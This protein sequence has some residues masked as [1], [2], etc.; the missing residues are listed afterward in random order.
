MVA[1]AGRELAIAHGAQF[2]AERLLGDR[3]LE[4]LEEPLDEV[5][6]PPAHH[7]VNG[8]DRAL[9][10]DALQGLTMRPGQAR[11]GTGRLAGEEPLRAR[12]R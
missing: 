6:Q 3:D 9:F 4:L 12:A 11:L 1:R 8:R 2:A 7:P 5:E 10:E